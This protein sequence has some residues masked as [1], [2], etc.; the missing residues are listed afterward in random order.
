MQKDNSLRRISTQ[1]PGQRY[2][3][4]L[5]EGTLCGLF[6]ET[7]D[8]SGLAIRCEPVRVGGRLSELLPTL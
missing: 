8:A 2:E 3:P 1:L 4:A 6:V 7:D 5:G